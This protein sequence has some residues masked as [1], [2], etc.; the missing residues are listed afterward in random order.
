MGLIT[1]QNLTFLDFLK[2]PDI[3]IP[4]NKTTFLAG[5]SGSGKSTL[6]KLFNKTLSP[7]NG[8]VF[9]K[10][11]DIAGLDCINL[12]R[13]VLLV[14]QSVYLFDKNITDNFAEFYSYRG[15][16]PPDKS[17]IKSYM[18]ICMAPLQGNSL[19]SDLSGGERQRV[20]LSIFLTFKPTVLMLDEPTSALDKDTSIQLLK[21]LTAH[22]KEKHITLIIINHNSSL[23][24]CFAENIIRLSKHE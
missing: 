10:G 23:E 12:R 15:L 13:E 7:S 24:D 17:K 3:E 19:C 16:E 18:D 14:P 5:E 1:T 11:Q 2:Y 9:Y 4:E 6:L 21:N 8:N 20:F 22:C